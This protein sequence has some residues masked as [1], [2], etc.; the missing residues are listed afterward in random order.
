MRTIKLAVTL[1]LL[2]Q[3][4]GAA[5]TVSFLNVGVGARYLGVGGAGTALADDAS[6]LYWNPA[7]L[8]ALDKRDAAASHAELTQTVRHDFLGYAQPTQLGTFAAGATYLSQS[9]LEGRDAQGHPT[10][11]FQASD[12]ALSL[13]YGRKTDLA[14]FGATAK[15]IQSH[16]GSAQAVTVALDLGARKTLG[17]LTL[18]AALRNAGPGMKYDVQRNDLPLRLAFGAAYKLSG[19]HALAAEWTNGPRGAGNDAGFGGEYQAIKGVFLRAGYTTQTAI[20]GGS[21]FDAARGLTMGLGFRGGA[22]GLDYAAVPMGEL[23]S[24]HRFTLS[25]RW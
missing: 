21:N 25:S 19:G 9:A 20:T 2:A 10:G 3:V 18:G 14:D 11:G 5:E 4:A 15:Y 6:A 1:A 13:G 7:G 22:W 23:G 12:A 24:T 17:V 16:I 8:A